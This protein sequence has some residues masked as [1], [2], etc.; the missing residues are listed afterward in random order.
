MS[1]HRYSSPRPIKTSYQLRC[2]APHSV[3]D[4]SRRQRAANGSR[5]TDGLLGA[6]SQPTLQASPSEPRWSRH[7]LLLRRA[8]ELRFES[9]T[10]VTIDDPSAASRRRDTE[11]RV[12]R[13]LTSGLHVNDGRRRQERA[14]CSRLRPLVRAWT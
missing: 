9:W 13:S 3:I 4:E 10:R 8:P 1:H 11:P 5:E 14:R 6:R 12:A 2:D 7:V